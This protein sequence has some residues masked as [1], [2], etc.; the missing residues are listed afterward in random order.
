VLIKDGTSV[1]KESHLKQG[2]SFS[3]GEND[4]PVKQDQVQILTI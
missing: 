2:D 3:L 1:N 4:H